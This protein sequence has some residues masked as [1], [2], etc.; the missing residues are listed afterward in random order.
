MCDAVC[1]AQKSELVQT[2]CAMQYFFYCI[3]LGA[4]DGKQNLL[5]V[6]L[7]SGFLDCG[8]LKLDYCWEVQLLKAVHLKLQA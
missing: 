7:I 8:T 6:T 5:N 3:L 2:A 1:I 4:A